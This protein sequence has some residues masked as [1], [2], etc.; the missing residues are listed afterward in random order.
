MKTCPTANPILVIDDEPAI[1]KLLKSSLAR[2]GYEVDTAANGQD[3]IS[4]IKNNEYCLI[5]T[6]IKMPGIS[7]NQV[8]DYLRNQMKKSIPVIG[9]SGTPWLL[10]D[11]G[12]DA[13]LE[14]PYS[15]PVMYDLVSRLISLA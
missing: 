9:M 3:G 1:L 11:K 15:M 13:I 2:K 5:I 8:L 7:G 6:D 4:K 12:F 14:K 10:E